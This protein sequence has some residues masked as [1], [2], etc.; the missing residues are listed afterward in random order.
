[1]AQRRPQNTYPWSQRKLRHNPFPRF[2][3]SA[4]DASINNEIFIFGG[5]YQG[6]ATND[7]Y[8]IE[9]SNYLKNSL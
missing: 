9:T 4:N 2:E 3:H 8:V 1:M 6:Q 5:I 7:V